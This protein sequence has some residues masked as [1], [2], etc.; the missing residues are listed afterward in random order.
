MPSNHDLTDMDG[1]TARFTHARGDHTFVTVQST[2][3]TACA[4]PFT[5]AQL[6]EA[7]DA[8]APAGRS[9]GP[10]VHH[11]AQSSDKRTTPDPD[12]TTG[13]VLARLQAEMTRLLDEAD[14]E[15]RDEA[16]SGVTAALIEKEVEQPD[17]EVRELRSALAREVARGNA[18]QDALDAAEPRPLTAREHMDAAW[19]AAHVPADGMIPAGAE[20]ITRYRSGGLRGPFADGEA[21]PDTDPTGFVQRRLL[22]PPTPG[23]AD[24]LRELLAAYEDQNPDADDYEGRLSVYLAR[25]G[26]RVEEEKR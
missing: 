25:H 22:D 8:V 4:G 26:A 17:A 16:D 21:V 3:G 24:R 15:L 6:V 18:L 12:E 2:S 9:T 20:F 1:D 7:L 11:D 23:H 13:G 19:D 5:R 10:H 14:A